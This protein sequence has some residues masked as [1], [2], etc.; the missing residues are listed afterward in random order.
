[1][2]LRMIR[3]RGSEAQVEALRTALRTEWA[4][5]SDDLARPNRVHLGTRPADP[6]LDV[7]LLACWSSAEAAAAADAREI[8]ALALARRHLDA[9][10]LETFEVDESILRWSED[11]PVAIRVATGR[12]SRPGADVEMLNLLRERALGIGD[13]MAEAY[14]GRRMVDRSVE[15]TF[16]SAWRALPAEDRLEDPFWSDIALRYDHFE[17]AAFTVASIA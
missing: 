11:A 17:V 6:V 8:S 12:F 15:V 4:K 10:V 2:I 5:A 1:M 13:A 16:V 14:V 7:L 3:G 9:V